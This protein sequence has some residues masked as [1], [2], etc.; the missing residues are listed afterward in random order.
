MSEDKDLDKLQMLWNAVESLDEDEPDFY[1]EL[2][3][4]G[5]NILHENPAMAL[6][7]GCRHSWSNTRPR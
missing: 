4:A 3:Q 1:G 5:W 7:S 2:K 6:T